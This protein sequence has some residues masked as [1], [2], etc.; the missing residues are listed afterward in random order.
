MASNNII[1]T[2]TTSVSKGRSESKK[3]LMYPNSVYIAHYDSDNGTANLDIGEISFNVSQEAEGL[4]WEDGYELACYVYPTLDIESLLQDISIEG[5][6]IDPDA[7]I[8]PEIIRENGDNTVIISNVEGMDIY[9]SGDYISL[10]GHNYFWMGANELQ[11]TNTLQ[12]TP[13]HSRA[14]LIPGHNYQINAEYVENDKYKYAE[15][16]GVLQM[17]KCNTTT[18]ISGNGVVNAGE[19]LTI[20]IV[21]KENKNNTSL[22]RGY[23]TVYDGN[24]VVQS[25]HAVTGNNT[26]ITFNSNIPGTHDI[27]AIYTD[28]GAE[29]N[30]SSSNHLQVIVN[31]NKEDAFIDLTEVRSTTSNNQYEIHTDS[32]GISGIGIPLGDSVTL[33]GMVFDSNNNLENMTVVLRDYDG[34]SIA[35]TS[36]DSDGVFELTYA[37]ESQLANHESITLTSVENSNHYSSNTSLLITNDYIPNYSLFEI[38]NIRIGQRNANVLAPLEKSFDEY[39]ADGVFLA[40]L[41]QNYA[42]Y[43]YISIISVNGS[44][45]QGNDKIYTSYEEIE[46]G[47]YIFYG[48]IE[49]TYLMDENQHYE[50]LAS[51]EVI[52]N[53]IVN[54][55]II[56]DSDVDNEFANG[57]YEDIQMEFANRLDSMNQ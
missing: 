27:Y 37:F 18:T 17:L 1:A 25:N 38:K 6:F 32:S 2:A 44:I 15:G 16:I 50:F 35:S 49:P 41:L 52:D 48:Y 51:F 43:N 9:Y 34:Q 47:E 57:S 3:V 23:I 26:Q 10:N 36:T 5:N 22:S 14:D 21:V 19:N 40:Q 7:G 33:T 55:N 20:T 31:Q 30:S 39:E 12:Y 45:S 4:G 29:Y 28:S 54:L 46:E 13:N 11:I 42:Q 8:S 24:N 53:E 56:H